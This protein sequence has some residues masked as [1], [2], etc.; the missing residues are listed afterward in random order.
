MTRKIRG[1]FE[2]RMTPQTLAD[3]AAAAALGHFSLAKRYEGDLDAEAV[4]EMLTAGTTVQGS[5]VYVAVERVTGT[6]G[7]RHGSFALHHT[8]VMDRGVPRLEIAVVPDSGTGELAG[9]TGTM[10]ITIAGKEHFYE[11]EYELPAAGG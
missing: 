7:G 5:A 11:F 1:R 10:G 8:G 3:P 4:G 6:L 2:V 9:I